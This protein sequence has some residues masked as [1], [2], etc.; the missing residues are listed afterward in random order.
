MQT[1]YGC[2][3][4]HRAQNMEWIS[5]AAIGDWWIDGLRPFHDHRVGSIVPAG[6]DAVVRVMHP[7]DSGDE[8]SKTTWAAVAE[9]NG[10]VAHPNMQLHNIAAPADVTPRASDRHGWFVWEGDLPL[11]ET[12]TLAALLQ[13]QTDPETACIFGVWDGYGGMD[14]PPSSRDN[15]LRIPQ[16]NHC[17]MRGALHELDQAREL[18]GR[19]TPNIWWPMGGAWC[20]VSEIDF[21]WTYVAG[22]EA[23]ADALQA[24]GDLEAY[25]VSYGARH[26]VHGDHING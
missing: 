2:S 8:Q 9:R 6:F 11:G 4:G 25:R 12:R 21:A 24:S 18:L 7:L 5:D 14:I 22:S 13:P 15:P 26:T 10:R 19:Q 1:S 3:T 17:L 23:L 16:R 20:V